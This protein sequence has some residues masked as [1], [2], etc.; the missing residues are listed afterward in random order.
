M[1]ESEELFSRE[2]MCPSQ[3]GQHGENNNNSKQSILI[4]WR[5]GCFLF[6]KK[7]ELEIVWDCEKVGIGSDQIESNS[8]KK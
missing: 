4:N 7:L 5:I 6:D 8:E 3:C 1:G 2:R